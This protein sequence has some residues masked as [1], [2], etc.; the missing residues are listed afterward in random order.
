MWATCQESFDP[1]Q[2]KPHE[3]LTG[4]VQGDSASPA[5]SGLSSQRRKVALLGGDRFSQIAVLLFKQAN[6]FVQYHLQMFRQTVRH[7]LGAIEP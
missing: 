2:D 5:R 6:F 7:Q 1:V 4:G 3:W